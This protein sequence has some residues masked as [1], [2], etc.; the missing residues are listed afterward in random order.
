MEIGEEKGHWRALVLPKA[1]TW[2]V[3]APEQAMGEGG[4][5]EEAQ[6]RPSA[7]R[8]KLSIGAAGLSFGGLAKK[9]VNLISSLKIVFHC[10]VILV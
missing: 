3:R 5:E 2:Q 4:R 10:N 6:V 9:N 8:R 1:E 7:L